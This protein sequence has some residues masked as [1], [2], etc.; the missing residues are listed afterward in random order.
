M[1]NF[2][3]IEIIIKLNILACHCW[4]RRNRFS[5]TYN[6]VGFVEIDGSSTLENI[7]YKE[8]NR[9]LLEKLGN[10]KVENIKVSN[11]KKK[12]DVVVEGMIPQLLLPSNIYKEAMFTQVTI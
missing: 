1:K 8:E 5:K 7:N 12:K 10:I 2:E 6:L 11:W 9:I 4:I 3:G